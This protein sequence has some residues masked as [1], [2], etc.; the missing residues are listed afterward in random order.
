MDD[1]LSAYNDAMSLNKSTTSGLYTAAANTSCQQGTGEVNIPNPNSPHG[2]QLDFFNTKKC[3]ANGWR[4][5]TS[6]AGHI[7]AVVGV[8]TLQEQSKNEKNYR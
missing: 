7:L 1:I 8:Q 6:N 3:S 2:S 4:F 5:F